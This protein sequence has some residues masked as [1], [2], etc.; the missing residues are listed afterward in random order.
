MTQQFLAKAGRI[1]AW[2]MVCLS[3]LSIALGAALWFAGDGKDV[4]GMAGGVFLFVG[5]WLAIKSVPLLW[6]RKP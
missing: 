2:L 6:T 1:A 5:V 3:V 4:G